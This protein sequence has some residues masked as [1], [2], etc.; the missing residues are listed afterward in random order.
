MYFTAHPDHSDPQ[1]NE[2]KHFSAFR[3]HNVIFNAK[4]KQSSCDD[5]A[6]FLSIKTSFE[7]EEWYRINGV[8]YA[9][10]KDTFLVLNEDQNYSCSIASDKPVHSFSLFFKPRFAG[11]VLRGIMESEHALLDEPFKQGS[12]VELFQ[13]LYPTDPLLQ[14]QIAYLIRRLNTEGYSTTGADEVLSQ[15]LRQVIV[16]NNQE[17]KQVRHIK[18]IKY[19]TRQEIYRR[20]CIVRDVLHSCFAENINLELISRYACLS[21][22]QLI[23]QF[24]AVYGI[25]PHQYLTAVRMEHAATLLRNSPVSIIDITAACGLQ[26]SSAFCRLFRTHYGTSPETF[27]RKN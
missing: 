7:G 18:G 3:Q 4:V 1:F 5:H 23:R 16:L 9:V 25:T 13:K 14:Q 21:L 27:R 2:E 24:K 8:P 15:I 12:K 19:S 26:D 6:G 22:P 20:V 17:D 10:R 11:N